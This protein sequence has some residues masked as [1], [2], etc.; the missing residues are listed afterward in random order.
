M[1]FNFK[2]VSILLE[3]HPQVC[4][5]RPSLSDKG[6]PLNLQGSNIRLAQR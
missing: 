2:E 1:L 5:F 3:A 6:C 4:P